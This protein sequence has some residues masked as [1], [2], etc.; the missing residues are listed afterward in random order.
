MWNRILSGLPIVILAV[1]LALLLS[2]ALNLV[3]GL[4]DHFPLKTVQF[5]LAILLIALSS[6]LFILSLLLTR[7][8]FYEFWVTVMIGGVIGVIYL[9]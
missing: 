3:A 8:P 4:E 5:Y 7:H 1:A 2:S 6:N 9:S